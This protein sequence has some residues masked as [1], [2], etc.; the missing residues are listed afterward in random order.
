MAA[1]AL[2]TQ[3]TEMRLLP[4]QKRRIERAAGHKGISMSD[5]MVQAADEAAVR[6]IEQH[7]T[8]VLEGEDRDAFIQALLNPPAP[9]EALLLAARDYKKRVRRL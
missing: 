5:F 2:R 9:N 6:T 1:P 4:D 7:E 8:W 3:R